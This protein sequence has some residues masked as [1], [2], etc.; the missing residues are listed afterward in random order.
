MKLCFPAKFGDVS[1]LNHYQNIKLKIIAE[2]NLILSE[3]AKYVAD[4]QNINQYFVSLIVPKNMDGDSHK[5]VIIQ[6]ALDF[7]EL[8]VAL[9]TNGITNP[10]A[11]TVFQFYT[12]LKFFES[13]KPTKKR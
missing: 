9:M 5:N 1:Q 7:E 8:C 6:F 12:A 13:K 4:I 2:C 11:M 10:K 3:D